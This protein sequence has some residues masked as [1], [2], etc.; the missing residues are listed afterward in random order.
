MGYMGVGISEFPNTF[1]MLGPYSPITNS[2][3]LIAIEAQ[4]YYIC[5]FIDRYQT[6]PKIH[7][8]M[9][10]LEACADF[11]AHVDSF[12]KGA[13]WTDNCRNSHTNQGSRVPTV[14]PGSTLHYLE[15]LPRATL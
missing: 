9:P 1:T 4:A 14:W 15:A 6:E 5:A 8:M 13:V 10:T 2:P 3:T 7:S 11:K 12:M